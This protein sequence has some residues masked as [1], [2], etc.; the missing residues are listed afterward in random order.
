LAFGFGIHFC[1]GADLARI[2][3]RIGLSTLYKRLPGL[4]IADDCE[5]KQVG[6]IVFRTWDDRNGVRRRSPAE[7]EQRHRANSRSETS[8][9]RERMTKQGSDAV[10]PYDPELATALEE[11][12]RIVPKFE[13]LH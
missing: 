2:E 6:G 9:R 3:T 11:I 8:R 10:L 12:E 13:N 7:A 1:L 5:P 4:R